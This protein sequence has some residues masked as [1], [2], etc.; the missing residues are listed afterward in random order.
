MLEEKGQQGFRNPDEQI[1]IPLD[2]ARY[3]VVGTDNLDSIA[4]RM[5]KGLPVEQGIADIERVLRREHKILPGEDNDFPACA[6]S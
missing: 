2:T 1:W 5:V 4:A 3:R 6:C